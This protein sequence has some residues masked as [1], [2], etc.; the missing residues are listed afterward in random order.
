MLL[1]SH[2]LDLPS[3]HLFDAS[4]TFFFVSLLTLVNSAATT[5]D[6]TQEETLTT[7]INQFSTQFYKET[8][9]LKPGE[10]LIM[11]P[12]SAEIV[13]ALLSLGAGG[14]TLTELNTA[15]YLPNS[16]FTKSA[17]KPAIAKL[18]SVEG[19]T[20]NIANKVFVKD[21][22]MFALAPEFKKNAIDIFSSDIQNVDF[23]ASKQAAATINTWVEKKTNDK[24]KDL[25]SADS[26]DGM[27]RLVLVNA[28]YFKGNWEKKFKKD[29]TRKQDFFLNSNDKVQVDMM[30]QSSKFPYADLPEWN[31]QALEM[32]YEKSDM[33]MIIIL[34]NEVEG[35]KSLEE[36]LATANLKQDVFDKLHTVEVQVSLPKF[37]IET[38]INL[39]KVL[40]KLGMKLIF[41]Q[42]NANLKGLLQNDEQ[43][44]V[45]EAIQKAFIEVN[46]EG[47]EAAA[48]TGMMLMCRGMPMS[49]NFC[50]D[51]PFYYAIVAAHKPL[52]VGK[53]IKPP[54]SQQ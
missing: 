1:A 40:P 47:A 6:Q 52:F 41:D 38:E 4:L 49:K 39:T 53:V 10:N 33:S 54:T 28:I 20:L 43:L 15:L 35:L 21:G 3:R 2:L 44:Y 5:M 11:S 45:S 23:S 27:T 37:K 51:R 14:N 24:I 36:K 8:A 32:K 9:A 18:N 19:V 34:P 46:E 16:E 30:Y 29:V 25:I 48:A 50:G 13:L 7:S 42:A 17:F 22:E 26:L 31:A 12:L